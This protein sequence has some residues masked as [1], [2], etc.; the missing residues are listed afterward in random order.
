MGVTFGKAAG[1]GCGNIWGYIVFITGVDTGAANVSPLNMAS[2]IF[3]C[4]TG[5]AA[6]MLLNRSPRD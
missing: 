4:G 3:V 1:V 2:F 6:G 5:A